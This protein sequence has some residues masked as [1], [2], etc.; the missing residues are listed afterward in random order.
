MGTFEIVDANSDLGTG[1][2]A[3]SLRIKF[4]IFSLEMTF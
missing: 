2:G 3:Q 4:S 1:F